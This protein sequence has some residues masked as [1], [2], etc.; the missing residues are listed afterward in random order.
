M[1]R[2]LF[3]DIIKDTRNS[4]ALVHVITNYVAVKGSADVILAAGGYAVASDAPDDSAEISSHADVL[5]ANIGMLH[6]DKLLAIMNSLSVSKSALLDPVGVGISRFRKEAALKILD[7]GKIDV[8][9]GNLSEI[10]ALLDINDSEKGIDSSAKDLDKAYEYAAMLANKY[11]VT[12]FVSGENDFVSNG[13]TTYKIY[14]GNE[15]MTKISG[16]GCSLSAFCSV[17]LKL[18]DKYNIA[19]LMAVSAAVYSYSGEMAAEKSL[20]TGSMG[21]YL[22]DNVG[23]YIENIPEI[24]DRIERI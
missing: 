17:F 24:W 10:K 11:S 21:I 3:E 5:C 6:R 4:K 23:F 18:K 16:A 20:Y 13:K 7:T 22:L 19:D 1:D 14:G 9:R 2:K 8:I 15:K 12:V